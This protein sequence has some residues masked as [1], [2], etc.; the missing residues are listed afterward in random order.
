MF[1]RLLCR[2]RGLLPARR[3]LCAAAAPA[4]KT[5]MP[6]GAVPQVLVA[7]SGVNHPSVVRDLSKVLYDAGGSVAA[8]KKV[9]LA[10]LRWYSRARAS[11]WNLLLLCTTASTMDPQRWMPRRGDGEATCLNTPVDA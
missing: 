6:V 10:V 7:V 4:S 3:A 1:S 2:S 11:I 5:P 8:T 9:R